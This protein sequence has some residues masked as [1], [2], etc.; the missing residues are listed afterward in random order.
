VKEGNPTNK[1]RNIAAVSIE[2]VAKGKETVKA[3]GRFVKEQ[4]HNLNDRRILAEATALSL[5]PPL[6]IDTI[7]QLKANGAVAAGGV[8]V[9]LA[10]MY[11]LLQLSE[12]TWNG[13]PNKGEN[14]KKYTL[15]DQ[16][17][18]FT[19]TVYADGHKTK[20]KIRDYK[21]PEENIPNSNH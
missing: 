8:V 10:I 14:Q 12:R 2:G 16:E 19:V 4:A 9:G 3:A 5:T 11:G 6:V 17:G 1:L 7:P 15:F 21:R 20:E 18:D 13:K